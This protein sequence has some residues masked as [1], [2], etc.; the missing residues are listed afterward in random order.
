MVRGVYLRKI[1]SMVYRMKGKESENMQAGKEFNE[2][3][4]VEWMSSLGI[5]EDEKGYMIG[6]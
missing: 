5:M 3:K 4:G 6:N 1:E 2:G